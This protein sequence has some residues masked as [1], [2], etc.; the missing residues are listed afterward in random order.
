MHWPWNG[1]CE[2]YVVAVYAPKL[3]SS[4]MEPLGRAVPM[5][6][7]SVLLF[8]GQVAAQLPDASPQMARLRC[9]AANPHAQLCQKQSQELD[10][11]IMCFQLPFKPRWCHQQILVWL[12]KLHLMSRTEGLCSVGF[13]RINRCITKSSN[14]SFRSSD[15]CIFPHVSKIFKEASSGIMVQLASGDIAAGRCQCFPCM[16]ITCMFSLGCTNVPAE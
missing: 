1:S 12:S 15:H 10:A 9:H 6:Y 4:C 14:N 2:I 16:Q 5:Q 3:S 7:A 13:Q 11:A 8:A